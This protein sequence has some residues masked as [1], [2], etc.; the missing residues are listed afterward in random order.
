MQFEC[1]IVANQIFFFNTCNHLIVLNT[2]FSI[3]VAFPG[4]FFPVINKKCK[5]REGGRKG[6]KG[7]T[8]A[9]RRE[10]GRED[11]LQ[12]SHG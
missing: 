4:V 8:G 12:K 9:G 5:G 3:F 6:R 1:N 2:W 11:C 7:K 10:G